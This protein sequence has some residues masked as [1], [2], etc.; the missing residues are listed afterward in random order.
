[1]DR[2]RLLKLIRVFFVLFTLSGIGTII[3][4]Y[5][6]IFPQMFTKLFQLYDII[7]FGRIAVKAPGVPLFLLLVTITVFVYLVRKLY[8]LI[9]AE[10]RKES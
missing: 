8:R 5:F 2:K 7:R 3:D 9:A 6:G 10:I 1:M 4:Y